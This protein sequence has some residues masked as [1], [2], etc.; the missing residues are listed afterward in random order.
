TSR[1]PVVTPASAP[2]GQAAA[3]PPSLEVRALM[4]DDLPTFGYPMTPTE[5]ARFN[6]RA[7]A[8]DFRALNKVA[9]VPWTVS[10]R[11]LNVWAF[12]AGPEA[13]RGRA[14]KYLRR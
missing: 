13:R 14:G 3:D 7:W 1:K 2:V 12:G 6:C 4:T 5:I 9:E 8:N 10:C 11:W